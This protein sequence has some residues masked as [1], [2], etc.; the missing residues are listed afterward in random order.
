MTGT[1]LNAKLAIN[2]NNKFSHTAGCACSYSG[3]HGYNLIL[4][5]IILNVAMALAFTVDRI[6]GLKGTVSKVEGGR[7]EK[8]G[9]SLVEDA[10]LRCQ[11]IGSIMGI[12]MVGREQ[13]G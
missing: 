7:G 1:S 4:A 6:S 13:G 5:Q 2:D 12:M 10:Q 3:T 9:N 11:K 8:L